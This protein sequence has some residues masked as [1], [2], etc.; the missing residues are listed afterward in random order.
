MSQQLLFNNDMCICGMAFYRK[1]LQLFRALVYKIYKLVASWQWQFYIV[2]KQR[3]RK[4]SE[5]I[6][7]D[8]F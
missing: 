4:K 6:F 8:I 3:W 1:A 7:T 5:S 2:N